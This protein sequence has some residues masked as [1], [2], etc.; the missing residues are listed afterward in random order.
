MKTSLTYAVAAAAGVAS[1][2]ATGAPNKTDFTKEELEKSTRAFVRENSAKIKFTNNRGRPQNRNLRQ[3]T[4]SRWAGKGGKSGAGSGSWSD[5]RWNDDWKHGDDWKKVDDWKSGD[6]WKK[7][8]DWKGSHSW[9]G[10]SGKSGSDKWK[11]DSKW[12]SGDDWKGHDDKAFYI[13]PSSCPGQC[14]TSDV[15]GDYEMETVLKTCRH[16]KDYKWNVLSDGSYVMIESYDRPHWCIAVDYKDGDDDK[17]F[18]DAC[19][20]DYFLALKECGEYGT[21]WYFT[22]GQM[23][24]SMCWAGGLSSFMAV[25]LDKG[26]E[27]CEDS[28][29]VEGETISDAIFR[30]DTFMFVSHLPK[31]PFELYD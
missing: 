15:N 31:A 7:V 29:T 23:V 26:K 17:F 20:G 6:D 12:R 21:Q 16:D 5:D 8:D 19:K 4:S 28:L 9:S 10:K 30:A 18:E 24:S 3:L 22:G 27:K 1:A 13:L 2:T 14:I 11:S 25:S